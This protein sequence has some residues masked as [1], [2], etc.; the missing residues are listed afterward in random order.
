[1]LLKKSS[2][3]GSGPNSSHF[4]RKQMDHSKSSSAHNGVKGGAGCAGGA[5]RKTPSGVTK[6]NGSVVEGKENNDGE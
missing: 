5:L 1:M 4:P 6:Q 3:P 2:Q